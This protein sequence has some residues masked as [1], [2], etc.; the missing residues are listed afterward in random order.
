[1]VNKTNDL[2]GRVV[3]RLTVLSEGEKDKYGHKRWLCR[4]DCGKE[5]LA[6]GHRIRAGGELSCGCWT[7]EKTSLRAGKHYK[8]NSPEYAAWHSMKDRCHNPTSRNRVNYGARGISV[9]REWSDSFEAFFASVGSRPSPD[10]SLGRIDNDGNYEPGNV[11]WEIRTDQAN[12]TRGNRF[13]EYRGQRMTVTQAIRAAGS[14]VAQDT[15]NHRF[16]R[17]WTV[18]AAVETPPRS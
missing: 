6:W 5:M 4:C 7:R 2:T 1:M 15:V 11:R 18:E 3:G 9:C 13:V 12:N 14:V 10:Y 17:G 8:R 16:K